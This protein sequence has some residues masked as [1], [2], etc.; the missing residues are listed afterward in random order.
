M[1]LH[2]VMKNLGCPL[3]YIHETF[4]FLLFSE[5]SA[6]FRGGLSHPASEDFIDLRSEA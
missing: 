4:N 5:S 1:S 3:K 6:L 2:Q